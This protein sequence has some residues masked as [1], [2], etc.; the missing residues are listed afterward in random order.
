M[1]LSKAQAEWL[2]NKLDEGDHGMIQTHD[3]DATVGGIM[4]ERARLRRLINQCTEKEFPKYIGVADDDDIT[5]VK[6]V[7]NRTPLRID[8]TSKTNPDNDNDCIYFSIEQ[9]K[10][11]TTGCNKIV[12][13]LYENE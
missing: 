7:Y 6:S 4:F 3:L 1:K 11:F 2:I 12:E 5:I 10:E 13:W 8:I 9:F